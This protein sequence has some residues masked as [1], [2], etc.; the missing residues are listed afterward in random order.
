M[1]FFTSHNRLLACS[2][3]TLKIS[4]SAYSHHIALI[5]FMNVAV[6]TLYKPHTL[7]DLTPDEIKVCLIL[8]SRFLS[9]MNMRCEFVTKESKRLWWLFWHNLRNEGNVEERRKGWGDAGSNGRLVWK[10]TGSSVKKHSYFYTV[11][12][13]AMLC[14]FLFLLL[15]LTF[16]ARQVRLFLISIIGKVSLTVDFRWSCYSSLR[17]SKCQGIRKS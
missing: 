8:K 5:V 13:G 14:L 17:C 4:D 15:L 9:K 3:L 12:P 7:H 2:L 10:R 1:K 6:C 11:S 16:W